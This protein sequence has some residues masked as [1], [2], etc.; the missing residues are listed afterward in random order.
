MEEKNIDNN[1]RIL[2]IED[3]SMEELVQMRNQLLSNTE[4]IENTENQQTN[5]KVKSLGSGNI[6]GG[7]NMYPEYDNNKA[8]M[9]NIISLAVVTFLCECLFLFISP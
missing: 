6:T 3:L 1:E 7:L 5:T 4:D 2:N 8:G 9:V